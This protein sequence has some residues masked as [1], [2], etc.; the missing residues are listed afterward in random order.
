[1]TDDED[2]DEQ[3][4]RFRGYP[5]APDLKRVQELRQRLRTEQTAR[6]RP[7]RVTHK[8]GKSARDL[9]TYTL[10]PSLMIAGPIVGFLLGRGVE[11]LWGGEPWGGVIGLLVGVV[12]AFREVILLL[13]R[14]QDKE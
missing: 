4:D 11:K 10:I 1:M 14:K 6:S 7:S 13:K 3:P 9:G 2:R 8:V 5:D 12:A